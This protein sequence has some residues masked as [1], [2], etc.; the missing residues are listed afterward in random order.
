MHDFSSFSPKVKA[1]SQVLFDAN[2]TTH[3]RAAQPAIPVRVLVQVLLM[4]LFGKIKNGCI[5]NL[6]GDLVMA[7][8]LQRF[9]VS[10]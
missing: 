2:R 8:S 3:A 5:E 7:G 10:L 4:V 9:L 6:S 1:E